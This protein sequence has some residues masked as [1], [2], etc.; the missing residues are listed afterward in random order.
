MSPIII[1]EDDWWIIAAL[2]AST[3]RVPPTETIGKPE[4]VGKH[5]PSAGQALA[6][7]EA[8]ILK[9]TRGL[10][11]GRHPNMARQLRVSI[12][13]IYAGEDANVYAGI[14]VDN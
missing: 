4:H 11:K 14:N 8:Q 6:M 1:G 12:R 2:P 10:K 9:F 3:H 5:E 13:R 7:T